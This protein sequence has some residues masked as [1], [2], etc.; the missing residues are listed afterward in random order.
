MRV[1][2][3]VEMRRGLSFIYILWYSGI[4]YKY[5]IVVKNRNIYKWVENKSIL[6]TN[7]C[8]IQGLDISSGPP[9]LF[10][11]NVTDSRISYQGPNGECVPSG[12][13]Y[14]KINVYNGFAL[15]ATG[16]LSRIEDVFS[17]FNE[18]V[19]H[20]GMPLSLE[21]VADGI[22]DFTHHRFKGI[23]EKEILVFH[24]AGLDSSGSLG[25]RHLNISGN[26][27]HFIIN[28]SD[29][30][31]RG[32]VSATLEKPVFYDGSGAEMYRQ[33]LDRSWKRFENAPISIDTALQFAHQFCR[34]AA[35]APGVNDRLQVSLMVQR[36]QTLKHGLFYP[37]DVA[38][39]P[40]SVVNP[41]SPDPYSVW[42][43]RYNTPDELHTLFNTFLYQRAAGLKQI[44][45]F[46]GPQA[47]NQGNLSALQFASSIPQI[48]KRAIL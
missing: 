46:S 10:A 21:S 43:E 12:E 8:S 15:S 28:S 45:F 41:A 16:F 1:I 6:M 26:R 27:E 25:I 48:P 11:I 22:M 19:R 17:H 24:L 29:Y 30:D 35:Q 44:S 38:L 18:I 7:L 36:E 14:R 9:S 4:F 13:N 20:S 42:F 5:L 2:N 33:F 40:Y 47:Q 3:D 34:Y 37:S 32:W 31:N 23:T 39:P